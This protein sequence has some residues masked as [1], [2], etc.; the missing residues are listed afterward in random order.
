MHWEFN[1]T[2]NVT[3]LMMP[4]HDCI[5]V[6]AGNTAKLFTLTRAGDRLNISP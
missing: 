4:S 3:P 6:P 1:N 5:R 2:R